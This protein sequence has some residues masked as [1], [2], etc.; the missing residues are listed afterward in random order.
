MSHLAI[1]RQ[2]SSSTQNQ[3]FNALLFL[4]RYVLQV[5][6]SDIS[7]TVRA[8][9][10]PRLPAVLSVDEVR[11]LFC[12]LS[13]RDLLIAHILYGTGMRLMELARLRVS[14]IDL[15][16][17]S[18]F[19][20]GGKG[21]KDRT[22]V[23]PQAV[24]V[25][26][27]EHLKRVK[28]L[29]NEDLAKGRGE[30]NLPEALERKYPNAGKEWRWQYVFPANNF[31]VDPRSGKV[32]RHHISPDVVQRAVADAVRKANIPK[33]ATVHTL[34]HSFATHLLMSGVNIREV[35]E[36][37]GHKNVETTMIYTHV[38]RDMSH[39]PK[40]PLDALLVPAK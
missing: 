36:L 26:L 35:Q 23:L 21:D 40:S 38:L 32:R 39:A 20:R 30:A 17:N 16:D 15:D 27:Q 37:L 11:Q 1:K 2:V 8:K 31:S 9:R 19:V 7:Q 13:G 3:A 14:D 29:H 6:L 10:G 34:R 4:F 25:P 18:I 22:T 24:V 33:H 12:H 5:D 28:K